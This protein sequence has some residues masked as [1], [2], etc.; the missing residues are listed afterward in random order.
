MTIEVIM[1]DRHKKILK[2]IVK[3]HIKLAQPISSEYLIQKTG[4]K[5][6]S[7]TIRNEMAKLEKE[8]YI[9]QPHTSAG[10]IPTEKG[11][12]YYLDNFL[13]E[14]DLEKYFEKLVAEID[15][16]KPIEE[17]NCKKI[18]KAVS[19][20]SGQ[21]IIV[22][23][24]QNNIYYTGVFNLFSQP[25]FSES[26]LIKN[27]SQ[28]IDNL[29]EIIAKIYPRLNK[30]IEIVIGQRNPFDHQLAS[31]LTKARNNTLLGLIG[32]LRMDYEKNLALIK[33]FKNYIER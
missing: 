29:D 1:I 27:F 32:P 22:S 25:E 14:K 24:S 16:K 21:T 5:L 30:K 23:F 6:S 12:Q 17:E 15:F 31:I 2:E 18:A 33:C 9:F 3:N 4:I 10:R 28:I 13:E 8:D 26:N 11:Y 7:A 19:R 20:V